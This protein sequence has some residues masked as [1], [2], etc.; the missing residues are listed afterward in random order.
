MK[1]FNDDGDN[2]ML[3]L[4]HGSDGGMIVNTVVEDASEPG[5]YLNFRHWYS[6][7][8]VA[9]AE[10]AKAETDAAIRGRLVARAKELGVTGGL[11]RE[12][13]DR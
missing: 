3:F 10:Y 11:H 13:L 8:A 7:P 9:K 12:R 4:E 1:T 6:D 2:I 5:T